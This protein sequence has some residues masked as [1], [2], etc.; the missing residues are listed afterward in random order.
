ME[1]IYLYACEGNNLRMQR[2]K[3]LE[4]EETSRFERYKNFS[5]LNLE[6]ANRL[7]N[8]I[9]LPWHIFKHF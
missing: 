9:I 5:T 8:L 6:G 7:K 1:L 3:T 4:I 2:P